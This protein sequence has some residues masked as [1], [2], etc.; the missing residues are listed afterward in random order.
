MSVTSTVAAFFDLYVT[1][2]P[3]IVPFTG[4]FLFAPL[5]VTIV[6]YLKD[7]LVILTSQSISFPSTEIV[8]LSVPFFNAY[9]LPSSVSDT[10]FFV[11][12]TKVTALFSHVPSNF[13]AFFPPTATI[14]LLSGITGFVTVTGTPIFK[15]SPFFA[16]IAA[17]IVVSPIPT[18]SSSPSVTFIISSSPEVHPIGL[19]PARLV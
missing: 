14:I 2:L 4:I 6:V 16:V 1:S 10:L 11:D 3:E 17:F 19:S 9:N 7:G 15:T 8:I 18:A 5:Y 12:L 13:I